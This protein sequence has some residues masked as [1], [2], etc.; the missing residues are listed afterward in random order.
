[1]TI[2]T[3]SETHFKRFTSGF[4]NAA[5]PDRWLHWGRLLFANTKR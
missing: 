2:I 4:A 1:M 3:Q 5:C